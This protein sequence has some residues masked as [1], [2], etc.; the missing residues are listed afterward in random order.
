MNLSIYIL[1]YNGQLNKYNWIN[2]L[3]T[4]RNDIEVVIYEY[5]NMSVNSFGEAYNIIMQNCTSKY[6]MLLDNID[7]LDVQE[8]N[9]FI[10][11]D[12]LTQNYQLIKSNDFL[13]IDN[14]QIKPVHDDFVGSNQVLENKLLTR[15]IFPYFFG[16]RIYNTKFIKN[17]QIKFNNTDIFNDVYPNILLIRNLTNYKIINSPFYVRQRISSDSFLYKVSDLREM[18]DSLMRLNIDRNIIL[19]RLADSYNYCINIRYNPKHTELFLGAID[20]IFTKDEFLSTVKSRNSAKIYYK[21]E[22]DNK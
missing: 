20:G 22:H 17:N 12:L 10:T 9:K 19:Y 8:F 13:Y 1:H 18:I 16:C 7:Y 2:K 14:N 11:P 15:G 6:F 4:S 21:K 3:R 5:S